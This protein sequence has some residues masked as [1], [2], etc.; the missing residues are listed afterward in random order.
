MNSKYAGNLL[1]FGILFILGIP[2]GYSQGLILSLNPPGTMMRDSSYTVPILVTN[3]NNVNAFQFDILFDT[4]NFIILTEPR[5]SFINISISTYTVALA[6]TTGSMRIIW[7]SPLTT[8]N[9]GTA[10]L[11]SLNFKVRPGAKFGSDSLRFANGLVVDVNS[12]SLHPQFNNSTLNIITAVK[13]NP[14]LY[15][16]SLDQ[17]YPNPFNPS[18]TIRYRLSKESFVRLSTFDLTGREVAL[19]VREKQQAGDYSV[20]FYANMSSLS[21]GVYFYKLDAGTFHQIR[22]MILLK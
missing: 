12:Q 1:V 15:S 7:V 21:S 3:F 18:T 11:L 4:T 6:N 19:L 14:S 20:P 16:F 5:A 2:K 9:Y 17:N 13:D 10:E 22:K 8:L